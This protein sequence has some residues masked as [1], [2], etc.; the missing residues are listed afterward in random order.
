MKGVTAA[1]RYLRL[2][3]STGDMALFSYC[4]CIV[5]LNPSDHINSKLSVHIAKVLLSSTILKGYEPL[6]FQLFVQP[7]ASEPDNLL[8]PL[9]I[10]DS[11]GSHLDGNDSILVVKLVDLTIKKEEIPPHI[12]YEQDYGM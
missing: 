2:Y 6:S 9:P 3:H 7:K 4:K 5:C 10:K 8:G 11:I 12:L 1:D